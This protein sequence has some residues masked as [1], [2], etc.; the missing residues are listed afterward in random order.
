MENNNGEQTI[1]KNDC[2]PKK[3]LTYH[4]ENWKDFTIDTIEI[5]AIYTIIYFFLSIMQRYFQVFR[6]DAFLRN[7]TGL[8]LIKF[9]VEIVFEEKKNVYLKNIITILILVILFDIF[10]H[11][12]GKHL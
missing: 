6:E 2:K 11:N 4:K 10:K 3:K 8:I 7:I 1:E 5:M 9:A 12:N